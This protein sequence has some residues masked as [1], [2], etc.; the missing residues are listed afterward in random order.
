MFAVTSVILGC[1]IRG[2][3]CRLSIGSE[4]ERVQMNQF[5]LLSAATRWGRAV[6]VMWLLTAGRA[7]KGCLV[8]WLVGTLY[9][10]SSTH[11]GSALFL[12]LWLPRIVAHLING[13]TV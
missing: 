13:L 5:I 7:W 6:R 9:N 2:E 12:L 3:T 8:G 11:P 10:E 1:L 4:S